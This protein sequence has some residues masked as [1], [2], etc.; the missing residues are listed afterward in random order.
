MV[1][2]V[3]DRKPLVK[4]PVSISAKTGALKTTAD[5]GRQ[6]INTNVVAY[7]PSKQSKDCV[8]GLNTYHPQATVVV[9]PHA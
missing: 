4:V 2:G 6:A 3:D 5:G 9:S 1:R 7:A 8:R